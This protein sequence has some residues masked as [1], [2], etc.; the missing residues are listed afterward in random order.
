MRILGA[1]QNEMQ[2]IGQKDQDAKTKTSEAKVGGGNKSDVVTLGSTAR[3]LTT[4]PAMNA[5]ATL[6]PVIQARLEEVR[7]QIKNNEYAID[8]KKLASNI[9]GD[10][11][12][13]SGEGE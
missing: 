3:Q 10:E 13:R 11:V 9:L 2:R 1:T 5:K 6:D 4:D 7:E 8:Y 12:A